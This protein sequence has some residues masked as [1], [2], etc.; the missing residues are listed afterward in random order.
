MSTTA[1]YFTETDLLNIRSRIENFPN[2]DVN[3]K[4]QY[5]PFADSLKAVMANQTATFTDLKDP[6]KKKTVEVEFIQ[7]CGL[8]DQAC[9][10]CTMGGSEVSTNTQTLAINICREVPFVIDEN[11]FIGNDFDKEDAIAKAFMQ[12]DKQLVEYLNG[13][14]IATIEANLGVNAF[15]GG[16]GTVAGT[17]TTINAANWD[18][19]LLAYFERVRVLNKMQNPYIL[20]G[21][22]LFEQVYGAKLMTD[23]TDDNFFGTL[24]YYSDLSGI[25]AANTPNLK[26]YLIDRGALAVT[27]KIFYPN[28]IEYKDA[29]R[30]SIPSQAMPGISYDVYYKNSC[31]GEF[32]KHEFKVVLH[33]LVAA[34]PTG[35]SATDTGI[36]AF[37]CA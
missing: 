35:C 18:A 32:Y 37:T 28:L 1:G 21:S 9:T 7:T 14:V 30:Y 10:D 25:D 12:A 27:S 11:K 36:L 2:W 6:S 3:V 26:T 17:A 13:Q 24:N 31:Y 5:Q 22:N 23:K 15:I 33:A 20:D 8:D 19:K 16:K 29:N 4:K 34:A